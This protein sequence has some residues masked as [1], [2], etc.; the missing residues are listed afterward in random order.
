M[1]EELK[2]FVKVW[3]SAIISVS[4]C[5]YIPSKIKSGVHRLL[6]VLPVCVLFLVLPLFFV[7][8]IFSS[9]TAFCLSIL[10]NFKLILFAFDKGPLLPL[11]ANLFR[12]ICFTCLPIKIQKNPN[13]QN[14]LPKWV[15]FCKAA[16]FGVLLN[17]HNYKSSLPPILLICLY[18]LHLYL[19]LD[20]LLTI[21]NALLTIIL[22]CDLEPHF[23]EPYLATSLQDFWGRRWNLMVPAIFRPG[24]YHPMRSVCQPQMRSDWARFMGCWTTFFVSGLIHELVYFYINRETPTWEVTWFFVLQGVCTAMEKAVKRKT[25][26]SLSPMLSRLITVGFL[27]VTGY[28]LFFRQIERSNMLERRATEASLIID[29]VKHKLSNFLL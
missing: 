12:F 13:S 6:S 29:F 22:G 2:S 15:F 28:F 27:V 10:A 26:W 11:P 16:I 17:V 4:Y 14:H 23:N 25:R 5:Y 8:T 21:V 18:P 3:G 20:V 7:F 24:V 1:E 19:V 9:T